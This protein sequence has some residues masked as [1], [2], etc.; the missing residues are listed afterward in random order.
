MRNDVLEGHG[1]DALW[2]QQVK[3]FCTS[4]YY[5]FCGGEID[6]VSALKSKT[7]ENT[8]VSG[9]GQQGTLTLSS[10]PKDELVTM[11]LHCPGSEKI[12]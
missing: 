12:I 11:N 2:V 4:Q 7:V 10:E 5:V 1:G 8:D 6:E 9:A 3:S